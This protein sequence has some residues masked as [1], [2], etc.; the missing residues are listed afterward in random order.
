[1]VTSPAS[2]TTLRRSFIN[3]IIPNARVAAAQTQPALIDRHPP[4]AGLFARDL[5]GWLSGTGFACQPVFKLLADECPAVLVA[6][7]DVGWQLGVMNCHQGLLVAVRRERDGHNA[8]GGWLPGRAAPGKA[9]PPRLVQL[10][11]MA[12]DG[13][14]EALVVD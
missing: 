6:V 11:V 13:K 3:A 7:E 8:A 2:L 4:V 10:Q 9:E 1:M 12:G 5:L 14:L